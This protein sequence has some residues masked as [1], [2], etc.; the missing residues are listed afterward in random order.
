MSVESEYSS[1]IEET[2]SHSE[3]SKAMAEKTHIPE[4]RFE[5]EN[6]LPV[7]LST[8]LRTYEVSAT[9]ETQTAEKFFAHTV[10]RDPE[11]V[12]T[13][14]K[15]DNEQAAIFFGQITASYKREAAVS[16]LAQA[17][18]D[19]LNLAHMERV[20]V[21]AGGITGTSDRLLKERLV[22]EAATGTE[23]DTR[24]EMLLTPRDLALDT[25]RKIARTLESYFPSQS[26]GKNAKEVRFPANDW[27][28]NMTE[29]VLEWVEGLQKADIEI[30]VQRT[31]FKTGRRPFVVNNVLLGKVAASPEERF[32]FE[33]EAARE[34]IFAAETLKMWAQ[35]ELYIYN[36]ALFEE[37]TPRGTL[38]SRLR[39]FIETGAYKNRNVII[40]S[41]SAR[42]LVDDIE[43]E[44]G[45]TVGMSSHNRIAMISR[46]RHIHHEVGHFVDP[47]KRTATRP[48]REAFAQSMENGFSFNNA[49]E[50][51]KLVNSGYER[52]VTPNLIYFILSTEPKGLSP[53]EV[54]Y[55]SST[56]Y[57]WLYEKLGPD[58][59]RT[60]YGRLTGGYF[61]SW[62]KGLD[63]LERELEMREQR[64]HCTGKVL[65]CL[66]S[67]PRD[68]RWT[69]ESSQECVNEYITDV[70]QG[71]KAPAEQITTIAS[72]DGTFSQDIE[73]ERTAKLEQQSRVN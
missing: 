6:G 42:R 24:S 49:L 64:Q 16:Y 12:I 70:N 34:V 71:I 27:Y 31:S 66:D 51:L 48:Q 35:P 60:F 5:F 65:N 2:I 32:Y 41:D 29:E 62:G 21:P 53:T 9:K 33:R 43:Y 22:K 11:G 23:H 50:N 26:P 30:T 44:N 36:T 39:S 18:E 37:T 38:V 69:W 61:E 63:K 1:T 19:E 56:F 17:T 45:E 40:I 7:R 59:F 14:V 15:F 10:E 57:C 20:G 4:V 8:D 25:K 58:A 72:L 28:S 54:Y 46:S 55:V 52:E 73:G 47:N 68:H 67:L 3:Y 13:A